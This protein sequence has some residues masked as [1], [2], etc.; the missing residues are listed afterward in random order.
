MACKLNNES[1]FNRQH[2]SNE[3]DQKDSRLI[4]SASLSWNGNTKR[5]SDKIYFSS[6]GFEA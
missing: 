1:D 3:S 5:R 2:L 4:L 6:L